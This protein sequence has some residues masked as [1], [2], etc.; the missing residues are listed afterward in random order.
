MSTLAELDPDVVYPATDSA[1]DS[2]LHHSRR[3][4]VYGALRAWF[5]EREDAW[6]GA[7]LNVYYRYGD[8][9]VV[10]A[11]DVFVTFGGDAA[12]LDFPV[13]YRVWEVGA[14]P[15]FVLEIA[16]KRTAKEDLR[17]KPEKYLDMGVDEYWRFDPT[18][19]EFYSQVLQGDRRV[20]EVWE[21]VG[22][23]DDGEG[24][25]WGHSRCLGLDV[26]ADVPRLRFRDPASGEWLPDPDNA[27]IARY[28]AEARAAAAEARAA[29]A[30][31][32]LAALRG[33]RRD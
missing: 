33:R 19:G 10:V 12:A 31:A 6:V 18:G 32:E 30:E 11:P 24:R 3:F 21:P 23:R 13:S 27:P 14:P 17:T 15:G 5:W 25:L 2:D 20:G 28:A 9:K 4:L 8:P 1:P 26:F 16:S 22:I 29:A 7:D